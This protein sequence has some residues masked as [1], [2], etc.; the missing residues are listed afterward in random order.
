MAAALS[1]LSREGPS[2]ERIL[3][4]RSE[5]ESLVTSRALPTSD[6]LGS[7]EPRSPLQAPSSQ[8]GLV[9][10][11][12]SF[13]TQMPSGVR[14]LKHKGAAAGSKTM[15]GVATTVKSTEPP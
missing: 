2:G 6:C 7:R 15:G 13:Q 12:P 9:K 5:N 4:Q 3:E 1:R 11:H 8:C 14:Q 10:P